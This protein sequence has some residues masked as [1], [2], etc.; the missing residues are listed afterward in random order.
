VLRAGKQEQAEQLKREAK[1]WLD[2][3]NA[4]RRSGTWQSC[5]RDCP[6]PPRQAGMDEAER[7]EREGREMQERI[8]RELGEPSGDLRETRAASRSPPR[9]SENLHAAG[10]HEQRSK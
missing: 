7:L 2:T 4:F 3:C 9:R 5:G 6:T 1:S 10:L 8:Q